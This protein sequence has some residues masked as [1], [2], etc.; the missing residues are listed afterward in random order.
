MQDR[1]PNLKG[2]IFI[3]TYGRSGSTLLQSLLQSI[4]GAHIVGENYNAL[5]GLFR[6]G[7]SARKSRK[8]WG[9]K[10]QPATHPWH[11]ADRIDPD[12]FERRLARIFVQEIL[13]PPPDVRWIGFKEVRYQGL[14]E[15]FPAFLNFCRR[16]FPNPFFVFNSRNGADVAQSK[17]WARQPREKVLTMVETMDARFARFTAAHPEI[18]YH[19][20][21]ETTVADPASLQPLF[22]KLGEPFDI[23]A[24]QKA[25]QKR[26]TH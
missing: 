13:Q 7:R 8:T 16:T 14:G 2:T 1:Y 6:A 3:V 5:E 10:P 19:A 20:V 12:R 25:L 18:S 11:G 22:D 4:P 24:A 26:L 15:D 21:H 9:K 23:G 17:W